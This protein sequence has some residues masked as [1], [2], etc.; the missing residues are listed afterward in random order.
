MT[1]GFDDQGRQFDAMVICAIG[2]P[3]KSADEY[4]KRRQTV[5]D[6]YSAYAAAAG[7]HVN[8]ELTQAKTL[9]TSEE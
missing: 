3:R 6:Q 5:V 9:P 4:N 2:G 7:Q 1:H 8:G